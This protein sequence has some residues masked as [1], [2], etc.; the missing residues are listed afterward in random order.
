M[1][2]FVEKYHKTI[3]WLWLMW[4]TSMEFHHFQTDHSVYLHYLSSHFVMFVHFRNHHFIITTLICTNFM[5]N[6]FT[7]IG[8]LTRSHVKHFL[9]GR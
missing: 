5:Y 4:Q 6:T 8:F 9:L 1:E 3:K 2:Q 7:F